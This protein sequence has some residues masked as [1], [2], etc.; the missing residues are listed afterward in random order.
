MTSTYLFIPIKK[1][2]IYEFLLIQLVES[3]IHL[4]LFHLTRDRIPIKLRIEQK[5]NRGHIH[6]YIYYQI[7]CI[8][9]K[10]LHNYL[11]SPGDNLTAYKFQEYWKQ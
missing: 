2:E 4:A 6:T 10:T 9:L 7:L 1:K 3:I 11:D 8:S 5:K